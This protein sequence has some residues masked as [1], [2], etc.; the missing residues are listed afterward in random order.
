MAHRRKQKQKLMAKKS[1]TSDS[2]DTVIDKLQNNIKQESKS[3]KN[4]NNNLR[5]VGL[6]LILLISFTGLLSLSNFN[7]V[8]QTNFTN[9][10]GQTLPIPHNMPS[11]YDNTL[12]LEPKLSSAYAYAKENGALL[13]QLVCYCGCNNKMHAPFHETNKEC[14]WTVNDEYEPHAESCSTCVYIAL[15]AEILYENGWSIPNIRSF[16]DNQYK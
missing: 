9:N 1:S 10:Q 7:L 11:K 3:I 16:I 12:T 4:S 13:S 6:T 14:F 8:G 15:S 5:Y 2:I